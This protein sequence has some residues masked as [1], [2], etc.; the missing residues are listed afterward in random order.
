MYLIL[1]S[2][3]PETTLVSI[4]HRPEVA[5]FHTRVLTIEDGVLHEM[6]VNA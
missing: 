4:A 6:S 1:S 5:R 2:R 3:L